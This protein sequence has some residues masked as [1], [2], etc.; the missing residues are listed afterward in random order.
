MAE[1]KLA[2]VC[3]NCNFYDTRTNGCS[4]GMLERFI[5]AGANVTP[6]IDGEG[7]VIHRVC[8]YRRTEGSYPDD[9]DLRLI[10]LNEE[11][12]IRGC[13]I[14]VAEDEDSLV[15][16]INAL[17]CT[18][19]ISKFKIVVAHSHIKA[20]RVQEI[21]KKEISFAEY[22]CVK[23]F[24]FEPE[25]II[26]EAFRRGQNGYMFV[27]RSSMEIDPLMID[28]VNHAVNSRLERILH[29]EPIDDSYHMAVTSAIAYKAFRGDIGMSIAEKLRSVE[30]G[31]GESFIRTW[32]Q[33]NESYSS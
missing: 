10:K 12:Y 7:P 18:N 27:V 19:G 6:S 21:C 29:V 17:S 11:V 3:R 5:Q 15:N 8:Q 24:V 22:S 23:C 1:L 25:K 20:S 31:D 2:T 9:L 13:I 14:I 28:K 16:T 26:N 33:I 32:E 4:I 30:Q